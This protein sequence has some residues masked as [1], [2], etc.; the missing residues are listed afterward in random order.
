[1]LAF[2]MCPRCTNIHKLS[3][4]RLKPMVLSGDDQKMQCD[5]CNHSFKLPD[6]ESLRELARQQRGRR[7]ADPDCP[8][9]KGEGRKA[10]TGMVAG[11][12]ITCSCVSNRLVAEAKKWYRCG[13]GNEIPTGE[14]CIDCDLERDLHENQ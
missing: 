13:C 4:E 8:H 14:F 11:E 2:E 7:Y 10:G 9:C 1:M 6:C 5:V 12:I 3:P